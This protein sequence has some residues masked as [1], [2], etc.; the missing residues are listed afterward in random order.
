V[1]GV[2][3]NA[4]LALGKN[5]CALRVVVD[6][7][8]QPPTDSILVELIDEN[9]HVVRKDRTTG[10]TVSF[11]DFGPNVRSVRVGANEC[12]PVIVGNLHFLFGKTQVLHVFLNDCGS[13]EVLSNAC[14]VIFR[15]RSPGDQPLKAAL[16]E[17]PGRSQIFDEFGRAEALVLIRSQ[18][19]FVV[20]ADGFQSKDSKVDV[21]N[22]R[23]RRRDGDIRTPVIAEGSGS[24]RW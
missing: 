22:R 21:P 3:L 23:D 5:F 19:S 24:N 17:E 16:I 2:L 14:K 12:H 20:K 1:F 6:T 7:A 8:Q 18:R 9:G 15:V 4:G 10:D 11:C 13:G